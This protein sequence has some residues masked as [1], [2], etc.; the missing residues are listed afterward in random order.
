MNPL[1]P[2][3]D[4]LLGPPLGPLL[5]PP[6]GPPQGPPGPPNPP[7][8]STVGFPFSSTLSVIGYVYVAPVELVAVAVRVTV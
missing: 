8:G 6:P 2:L 1:G 5:D 3:L 4:P 7:P